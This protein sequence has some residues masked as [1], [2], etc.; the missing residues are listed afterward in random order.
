MDDEDPA[1]A[2][3]RRKLTAKLF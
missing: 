1:K 3:W 2:Q